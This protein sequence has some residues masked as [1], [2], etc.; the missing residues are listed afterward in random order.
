MEKNQ[1]TI[2]PVNNTPIDFIAHSKMLLPEIA[3]LLPT[4]IYH[5]KTIAT[6]IGMIAENNKH[7]EN[8]KISIIIE[9]DDTN[10][11]ITANDEGPGFSAPILTC[12]KES[13]TTYTKSAGQGLFSLLLITIS[14]NGTIIIESK[15]MK[16]KYSFQ[17]AIQNNTQQI[18]IDDVISAIKA[19]YENKEYGLITKIIIPLN[20]LNKQTA[21]LNLDSY[22]N[23]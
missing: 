8:N 22:I 21:H 20:S 6:I 14:C 17:K 5:T 18:M 9:K 7:N 4:D 12:I 19:N 10:L 15:K 23:W 13:F 16:E 1:I 3:T 2:A 11:K